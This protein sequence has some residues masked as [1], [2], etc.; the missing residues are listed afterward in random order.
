MYLPASLIFVIEIII[1]IILKKI[2]RY[3]KII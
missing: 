1:I 3:N 2:I